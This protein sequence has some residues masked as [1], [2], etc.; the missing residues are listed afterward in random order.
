MQAQALL[1]ETF[2]YGIPTE[3]V[4]FN[5]DNTAHNPIYQDAWST[6][7]KYGFPAPGIVSTSWFT[8]SNDADRWVVTAPVLIS[9]TGYYFMLDASSIDNAYKDG[10]EIRVSTTGNE[11]RDNFSNPLLSISQCDTNFCNFMVSL[12]DYVG[13]TVWVAVIQN[14]YDKN[15]LIADNFRICRP[16]DPELELTRIILPDSVGPHQKLNLKAV[17]T[18]KSMT[19]YTGDVMIRWTYNNRPLNVEII[20]VQNLGFNESYLYNSPHAFHLDDTINR[21]I[22]TIYPAD[23]RDYS[24]NNNTR[25]A[26][27]SNGEVVSIDT[28]NQKTTVKVYPNPARQQISIACDSEIEQV[29]IIDMHGRQVRSSKGNSIELEGLAPGLY[30]AVIRTSNGMFTSKFIKE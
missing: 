10:I 4:R 27:R 7:S 11:S 5:D 1:F 24:N 8:Q 30:L 18:N 6:S 9:D 29:N 22:A 23:R 16:Y 21:F 25:L 12:D 26:V 2:T 13:D 20:K 14:S 19:P 15:L 28:P 17:I 3:W